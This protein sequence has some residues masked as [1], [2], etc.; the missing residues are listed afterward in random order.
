[1]QTNTAKQKLQAGETLYGCFIRYPEPGLVEV[2][3]YQG[4]DFI[5]FDA[6]HGTIE[7]RDC[8][9][10]TRAAELRGVTPLVRVTTNQPPILLRFLDTGV[11][12]VQV[13]W[14]NTGAEARRA[15]QAVKYHPLGTRGLAG[16]RAADYAQAKPLA[17]Y[18]QDANR[19]TLTILQVESREGVENVEEIA[20]TEG[21]D[22]LFIGP[23]DLSQSFGYPGQPQHPDVQKAMERI[24]AAANNNKVA[25]GTAVATVEATREWRNR[26]A[27]YLTTTIEAML[28]QS[29]RSY[30]EQ[31]KK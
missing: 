30:L 24:I 20:A 26:G 4:W 10:M 28:R 27:R 23:A 14:V 19:E 18:V 1:M 15:V 7:P 9:N 21:L 31:V 2:M 17:E 5:T 11:Q 13:P 22:I 8:E 16:V 3:G 29:S 6:E 25:I 12:G